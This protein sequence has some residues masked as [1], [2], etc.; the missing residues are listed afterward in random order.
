M[1]IW[2]PLDVFD[3]SGVDDPDVALLIELDRVRKDEHPSAEAA[4][5]LAGPVE[6]QNG[7]QLRV[8]TGIG[9]TSLEHPNVAV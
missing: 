1:K 9:A 6:L 5:K 8:R 3:D 4:E 2:F 7:V